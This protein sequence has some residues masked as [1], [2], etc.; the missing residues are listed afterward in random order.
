LLGDN[1][2]RRRSFFRGEAMITERLVWLITVGAV[3]L[4]LL[5]LLRG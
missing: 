4:V 2:L 1:P 5:M 3:I